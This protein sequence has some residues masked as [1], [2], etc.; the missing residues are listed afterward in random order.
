[1]ENKEPRVSQ[2]SLSREEKI[3]RIYEVIADK[4]LNVGCMY[5]IAFDLDWASWWEEIRM[6]LELCDENDDITEKDYMPMWIKPTNEWRWAIWIIWHKVM[7][8]D[9]FYWQKKDRTAPSSPKLRSEIVEIWW[10]RRKPIEE[11][12]D[13]CIDYVYSLIK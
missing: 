5:S 10:E 12:S 7:I 1:M 3:K 11:Q 9:V 2:D 13:E 8:W 4:T 6:L